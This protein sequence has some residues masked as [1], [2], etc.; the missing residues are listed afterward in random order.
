MKSTGADRAREWFDTYTRDLSSEDLQRLFTHDTR[1]AYKFFSRGTGRGS[2]RAAAVVEAGR[3]ASSAGVRRFHAEAAPGA[4]GALSWG[5]AGCADRDPQAVPRVRADGRAVRHALLPDLDAG[6][7]LGRRDLRARRQPADGEPARAAGSGRSAVPQGR[8]RG[9]ARD[10]AGDAAERDVHVR[11]HRDLRRHAAGQHR[12]RR[13]LRRPAA[14]RRA[15][16]PRGRRR[17]RKGQPGGAPDGAAAGD[18]ANAGRRGARSGAV[19]DAAERPDLAAQPRLALHHVLLR[20]LHARDRRADLRQRRPEPAAHPP[21]AGQLRTARRHRHR[22]RDVRSV[23]VFR[24]SRR[25]S[26]PARCWCSTAT[27][28]PRRRIRPASRSRKPG[29]QAILDSYPDETP[30]AARQ[31]TSSRAWSDTRRRRGSPTI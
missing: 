1:D 2:G 3:R 26:I 28:S 16:D 5:P 18:A 23:H 22:A 21:R 10:P 25:G 14:A 13:F 27:A 15:R 24:G 7:S 19:D 12:G 20:D 30:A 8:A 4:A 9:R 29:L 31:R 11:R 6:A 17:R